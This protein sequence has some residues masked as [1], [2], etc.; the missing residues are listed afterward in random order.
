M[1]YNPSQHQPIS[2]SFGAVNFPLDARSFFY[3]A[4]NYKYRPYVST[5]EVLDYLPTQFRSGFFEI[6]VNDGGTLLNGII[7]G[8]R[9]VPYWFANGIADADLIV[10]QTN[11]PEI[12]AAIGVSPAADVI[13][14]NV[15]VAGTYTVGYGGLVVSSGELASGSVQFRKISGVWTKFIIPLNISDGVVTSAKLTDGAVT[16]L[17]TSFLTVGKNKFNP[18]SSG[19]LTGFYVVSANG[20][21][22][23][24]A[25]FTAS[26]YISV[27]PST[28]YSVSQVQ[29]AAYYDSN[30]VFISA[31][32][33]SSSNGN[34][35][36]TTAP[37]GAAYIRVSIL[38]TSLSTYQ[39]EQAAAPTSYERYRYVVSVASGN[40]I[41]ADHVTP[42]AV[43][44]I[45][46]SIVLNTQNIID[47]SVTL[48]KLGII[49]TGKNLFNPLDPSYLSGFYINS[50]N[51]LPIANASYSST[52]FIPVTAGLQ[53]TISI[54]TASN[55][56]A[57][58]DI[59]KAYIS[60]FVGSGTSITATAPAGAA[61]MKNSILVSSQ[62]ATFQVEQSSVKT[63]Y[64]SYRAIIK[65]SN[66]VNIY[67]DHVTATAIAEVVAGLSVNTS[68]IVD[69][70]V[71]RDKVN[72]FSPG[73]NLFYTGDPYYLSGYYIVSA[74][75]VAASNASYSATGFIPVTAGLQY[76]FGPTNTGNQNAWYDINKVYISGFSGTLPTK[77]ITAPAGAAYARCSVLTADISTFQFEQN[78]AATA[79]E[80]YRLNLVFPDAVPIAIPGAGADI[81]TI[82]GLFKIDRER[83]AIVAIAPKLYVPSGKQI[84]VYYD[85]LHKYYRDYKGMTDVSLSG[86]SGSTLIS[87]RSIQYTPSSAGTATGSVVVVNEKF[88]PIVT[89]PFQVIASNP[90]LTTAVKIL[91]MGDSYTQGSAYVNKLMASAGASNVTFLGIRNGAATVPTNL[92]CE[93]RGGSSLNTYMRGVDY[94]LNGNTNIY[95]PFQQPTA[96]YLYYGHTSFWISAINTPNYDTGNFNVTSQFDGTTGLKLVPN[97]NDLMYQDSSSSWK[98]WNGSAWTT[99]TAPTFSFSFAKY[100]Q[101]WGIAQP[102]IL[103]VML[104]TNE[105]GGASETYITANWPAWKTD[106]D[107]LITSV[108]GDSVNC[109]IIIGIPNTRGK[110][111][112][113]GIMVTERANRAFWYHANQ[114][115]SNYAGR[116]TSDK[117]W[118]NDYHTFVDRKFGFPIS[119]N[120][121]YVD[122]TGTDTE[123][124]LTDYVHL[125]P[126]GYDQFGEGYQGIIQA[127]R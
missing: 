63:N 106:M 102:D 15:S 23:V 76:A 62:L 100:R 21:T 43:A 46:G 123:N 113:D 35:G 105:W 127:L 109:K 60:G 87:G 2:K 40:L 91:N 90:S 9:N 13:I 96:T 6:V 98:Y 39:F 126:D 41:Y 54:A 121:P 93:G 31:A 69:K 103:H 57:W 5:A 49:S 45:Q 79:Y 18:S 32:S 22:A 33:F 14:A 82:Q 70:A 118:I 20:T 71:T 84:N 94:S 30:K 95:N 47:K 119:K 29:Q 7:T 120:K 25:S 66:G 61:Y 48:E 81:A 34:P 92:K 11:I 72:F 65:P 24:N 4:V 27:L 12:N 107:A 108:R 64:E 17:K 58:Y 88:D 116:E 74:N 77:I 112:D 124:F 75:G 85:N 67:A 37:S 59:N 68:Q 36:T 42:N 55:Q 101:A 110:Q 44:E 89:T 28:V 51:G 52:G 114:V 16:P 19:V 117:I 1:P 125:S 38:N 80:S 122:F 56:N 97:L 99:T 3:D 111:G 78:S 26:D 104:G 83:P 53:Y 8:G 50:A 115:I 73:K 10:K 86:G